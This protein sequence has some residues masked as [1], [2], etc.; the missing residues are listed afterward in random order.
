M[1]AD[2][3]IT[4]TSLGVGYRRAAVPAASVKEFAVRTLTRRMPYEQSWGV[5]GV[6]FCVARGEVLG[7][8]GP[9]GAGKSTLL[10]AL[11]GV[12]PPTEGRVV[13][14][15]RVTPILDL[16]TGLHPD[17][18]GRD[19]IV[20]LGCLMERDP[21]EMRRHA[22]GIADWAGLVNY[23]D[24]PIRTYSSGM[25]ARLAFAVASD[26]DPEVLLLDEVL[27]VG[28][29]DF[30]ARCLDRV[31][32]LAHGGAA[33]VL[34]SHDLASVQERSTEV[35]WLADGRQQ[36]IGDPVNVIG[37]YAHAAITAQIA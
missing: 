37:A 23:L 6:S 1:S 5:R 34:V 15:G 33:V 11:A 16:G 25:V 2:T 28:D 3:A 30:Q 36:M 22:A 35:L 8:V 10:R 29:A 13:V 24:R 26:D 27:A 4:V 20:F 14:N 31:E 17:A 21:R 12:I 18:T 7:V 19:C 32:R 9:N